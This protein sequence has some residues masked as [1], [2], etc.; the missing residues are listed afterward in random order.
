MEEGR[1]LEYFC[2]FLKGEDIILDC[3][4]WC[5]EG[6]SS[7]HVRDIRL[8]FINEGYEVVG[9]IRLSNKWIVIVF[10]C[11]EEAKRAA[12]ACN[13][14][15]RWKTTSSDNPISLD[16][17]DTAKVPDFENCM[18]RHKY[19]VGETT[20]SSCENM[21]KGCLQGGRDVPKKYK[22]ATYNRAFFTRGVHSSINAKPEGYL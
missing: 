21:N 7:A 20:E 5:Q 15:K 3:A 4:L 16:K 19:N 13:G 22:D 2:P 11:P 18:R 9:V 17:K 6:L 10:T 14:A 1:I 8:T 12:A